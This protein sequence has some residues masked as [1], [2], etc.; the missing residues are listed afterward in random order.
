MIDRHRH[1]KEIEIRWRDLDAF[2]HVNHASFVTFLEEGRDEWLERAI[3]SNDDAM[4]F[5]IRRVE[6]DYTSQLVLADDRVRVT[7]ELERIGTSSLTTVEEMHVIDDDRLVAA[8]RCVLV[9]VGT[10]HERAVPI[11]PALRARFEPPA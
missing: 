10:E 4:S 3:G 8:A 1:T 5:I 9:H 2:G 11:P 7:V 6:V